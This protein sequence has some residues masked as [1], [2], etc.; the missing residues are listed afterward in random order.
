[1]VLQRWGAVGAQSACMN[2]SL[3]L[4]EQS[5]DVSNIDNNYKLFYLYIAIKLGLNRCVITDN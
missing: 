3:S 2:W 1:M 5:I 4:V